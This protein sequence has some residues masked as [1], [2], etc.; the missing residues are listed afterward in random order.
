MTLADIAAFLLIGA[1][2]LLCVGAVVSWGFA[3]FYMV[4]TLNRFH[5][6]RKWGQFLPVCLF[7]PW[8]FTDEGNVYRVKLLKAGGVFVLLVGIGLTFGFFTG[9]LTS[10]PKTSSGS[11]SSNST[12]HTDARAKSVADQLPSARAGERGRWASQ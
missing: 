9:A 5:P 12:P 8:F 1:F 2:V 7:L 4:K 6:E 10:G 11:M 3:A